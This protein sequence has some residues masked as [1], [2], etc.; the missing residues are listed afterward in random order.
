MR[1]TIRDFQDWF[2]H[3]DEN[4]SATASR[5]S[6]RIVCSECACHPEWLLV[7]IDVEKAFLQGMTYKEIE[8]ATGEP[9]REILFSLPPGAAALLRKLP[10]FEDFDEQFEC[11]RA[12]KPGTGTKGAPRAF[13]MKLSRITRGPKC[14]MKP[15]TMDPELEVRH[16][17]RSSLLVP[18][19]LM[20]SS[21]ELS[22]TC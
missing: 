11:L 13:S 22:P 10:G 16:G 21:L 9:E 19:T 5:Q 2:A 6:Q 7:T 1:M 17:A 4:Y 20:T 14:K 3:L 12:L 8:D 15:T 18:N